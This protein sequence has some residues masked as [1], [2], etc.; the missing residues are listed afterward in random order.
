MITDLII[1]LGLGI[2]ALILIAIIFVLF[3]KLLG[4]KVE[5]IEKS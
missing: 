4:V 5:E 1:A 3:A 2:I